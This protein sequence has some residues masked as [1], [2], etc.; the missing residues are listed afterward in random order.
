MHLDPSWRLTITLI[1]VN[2]ATSSLMLGV[3]YLW[4]IGK[5]DRFTERFPS[6]DKRFASFDRR[7]DEFEAEIRAD[8]QGLYDRMD[9][10]LRRLEEQYED[11]SVDRREVE[12]PPTGAVR[13]VGTPHRW[14]SHG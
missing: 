2:L 11:E 1:F 12:L 7:M 13:C 9:A 6:F 3:F 4:M 8:I 14:T 10:R 5:F